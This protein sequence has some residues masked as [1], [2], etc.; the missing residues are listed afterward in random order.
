[1]KFGCDEA[2]RETDHQIADAFFEKNASTILNNRC[3][4]VPSLF[5]FVPNAANVMTMHLLNRL[6]N[7]IVAAKGNHVEYATVPRKIRLWTSFSRG[8]QTIDRL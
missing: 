1:M 6:N 8:S 4:V 7:H 3:L 5:N 2:A